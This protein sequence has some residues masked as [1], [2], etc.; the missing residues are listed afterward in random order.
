MQDSMFIGLDVHKAPVYVAVA[1]GKRGGEVRSWGV[2]SHRAD[3]VKSNRRS[4]PMHWRL[5]NRISQN[6]GLFL[7]RTGA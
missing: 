4:G 1:D 2:I 6:H 5:H 3:E 7:G